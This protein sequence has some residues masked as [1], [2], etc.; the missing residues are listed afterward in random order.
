MAILSKM[1]EQTLGN[2]IKWNIRIPITRIHKLVS[3]FRWQ[4]S[5]YY[6]NS[7]K[8][9]MLM[10]TLSCGNHSC[11]FVFLHTSYAMLLS[12]IPRSIPR[13]TLTWSSWDCIV[14]GNKKASFDIWIDEMRDDFLRWLRTRAR[15]TSSR[16]RNSKGILKRGF[17]YSTEWVEC[18]LTIRDNLSDFVSI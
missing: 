13:V 6:R 4:N 1:A 14:C 2:S 15:K 7:R 12:G 8:A 17:V 11:T 16:I 9:V 18:A 10:W 3:R 5:S